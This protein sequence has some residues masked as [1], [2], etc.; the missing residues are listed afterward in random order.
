MSDL[1]V[2]GCFNCPMAWFG[3][4]VRRN[5]CLHPALDQKKYHSQEDSFFELETGFPEW[6]PLKQESITITLKK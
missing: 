3:G 6:C 5:D 2:D 1:A 4:Y